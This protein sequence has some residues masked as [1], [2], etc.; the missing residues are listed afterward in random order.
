MIQ[1]SYQKCFD[2][3]N[4]VFRFLQLR[5]QVWGKLEIDKEKIC[6]LDFF[7]VFPSQIS[8]IRVERGHLALKRK[9]IKE[10]GNQIPY[11]R[12]PPNSELLLKMRPFQEA[13]LA[14]L[15]SRDLIDRKA[16]DRGHIIAGP[17]S[18]P[19]VLHKKVEYENTR[20]PNL[21]QFITCLATEYSLNG[22][23]GLKD[24][25]KLMEFRYDAV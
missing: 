12:L 6:I 20:Y 7:I 13:A 22:E 2:P 1:L 25:T 14:T 3:Y 4:A 9:A 19:D 5:S 11:A 21:M 8:T 18:P 17:T 23:N 15:A 24:R 10:T 16:W